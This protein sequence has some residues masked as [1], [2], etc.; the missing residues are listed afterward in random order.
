[1]SR[2]PDRPTGPR[3]SAAAGFAAGKAHKA[4]SNRSTGNV[5][6]NDVAKLAGVSPITVSRVINQP[7]MVRAATAEKVQQAITRTGYVPNLLA[8]GLASRRSHLIAVLIPS[9]INPVYAETIRLLIDRLAESGYQVLLGES[10]FRPESEEAILM[11]VLSRRPDAVFLTG[12]VHS[13]ESRRRLLNAQIPIVESWDLTPTPL[14]IV[15]GFSHEKVGQAVAD[16]FHDAGF[17]QV[18]IISAND[19]RAQLR[20][21]EF[22]ARLSIHGIKDVRVVGVPAPPDLESGRQGLTRL[23]ESGFKS[24]AI[25]CSSDTLA[26]GVLTEAI[27]RRIAIPE[28]ISIMGFGDQSFSAHT[29]PPLTTVRIDR[30]KMGALAAEALIDSI[31]GKSDNQKIIDIGF[32]I[33]ERE[34]T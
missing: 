34:T 14:D 26:H 9:I 32:Q 29:F 11:A 1:M 3:A 27:S 7:E 22:I 4:A 10:G 6:L 25:F 18:G 15:V 2:K 20:Q 5:T 21:H 23:L 30:S 8:G 28:E 16:Y 24:G 19:Q 33:I 31:E 12:T 13:A 17:R